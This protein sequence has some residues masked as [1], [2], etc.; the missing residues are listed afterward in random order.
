MEKSDLE[1]LREL[2]EPYGIEI[3]EVPPGEGGLVWN[4]KKL[5]PEEAMGLLFGAFEKA[6][7]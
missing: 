5:T 6:K 7:I 2:A 3:V 1:L 4:G